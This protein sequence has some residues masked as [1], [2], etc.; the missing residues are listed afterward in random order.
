MTATYH[1]GNLRAALL[2]AAETAL[3]DGG[4]LSLRALAREVGVSHAAPRR[5]FADKQALLDALA[6]D[7]FLRLGALLR[8]ASEN[9]DFEACLLAFAHAYV[10][11]AIDHAALLDLMWAGKHRSDAVRAAS[12]QAFTAPMARIVEAQAAGEVVGGEFEPVATVAVAAFHG[13]AAMVNNGMLAAADLDE[14]VPATVER[15]LD[16]LRPRVA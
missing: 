7:G 8:E 12:D 16:G 14:I 4:D 13:L 1:H 11:F 9:E 10:S 2:S 3:A 5:H 6:E 15:L